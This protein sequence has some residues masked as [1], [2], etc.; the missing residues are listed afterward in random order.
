MLG[1]DRYGFHKKYNGARYAK[2]VFLD[3]VGSMGRIL[4][5]YA[6]GEP[7]VSALLLMLRWD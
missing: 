1:C 2:L 4:H 7:N 3:P 5:S 6:F